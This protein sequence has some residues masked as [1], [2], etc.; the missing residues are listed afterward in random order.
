MLA[1]FDH[2]CVATKYRGPED[3][4][5]TDFPY[6][7]TVLHHAVGSYVELEGFAEDITECRSESDLP[8]AARDYLTFVAD[9]VG[10]PIALIGVGPGRE[11]VIWTEAS[12]ASAICDGDALPS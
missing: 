7:Q 4:E 5:F 9:F 10:V 12:R 3:A 11:Q 2:L 1:G 6:H 8:Q